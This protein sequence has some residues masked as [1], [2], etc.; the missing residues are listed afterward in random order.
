MP[1]E[2]RFGR[3]NQ[4]LPC[5]PGHWGHGAPGL[6]WYWADA[7]DWI[8]ARHELPD[9]LALLEKVTGHGPS[10]LARASRPV[11]GGWKNDCYRWAGLP[12]GPGVGGPDSVWH[13]SVGIKSFEAGWSY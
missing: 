10:D 11:I 7:L 8:A 12:T 3:E 13:G 2:S 1:R 9:G 6:P 5:P 4:A